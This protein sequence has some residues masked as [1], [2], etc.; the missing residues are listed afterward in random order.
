[1]T[2]L[3]LGKPTR[4]PQSVEVRLYEMLIQPDWGIGE[5]V[6]VTAPNCGKSQGMKRTVGSQPSVRAALKTGVS[7]LVYQQGQAVRPIPLTLA[8][9]N[10]L[11]ARLHR[12]H[13]PVVGHRFTIGAEHNGEVVGAAV[14]GRP[15]AR[16]TDQY[17]VAEVTRLVTDGSKNACSLLYGAAA[18]AAEAMGYDRIQTFI[19]EDEPGTSLK[20]AGWTFDGWTGGGDWNCPSRGG[21]RT[22]QPMVRK[23]RWA[24]DFRRKT[25]KAVAA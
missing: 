14:V 22:D 2:A 25:A 23:Q 15:V 24:K 3:V 8:E 18:R 12:H 11:I 1:M 21:R 20:A 7:I 19:L 5:P 17:R 9:A 6:D 13:K 10:A 4:L 16:K